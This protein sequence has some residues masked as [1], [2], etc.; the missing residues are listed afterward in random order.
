MENYKS[1]Y[2]HSSDHGD[3]DFGVVG[4]L[5]CDSHQ[6]CAE[7]GSSLA[8]DIVDSEVFARLVL[9][10][11]PGKMRSGERLDRAL[12]DC[13]EDG[14]EPEFPCLVQLKG[15]GSDS[16]IAQDRYGDQIGRVVFLRQFSEQNRERKGYNLSEE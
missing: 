8:E 12:E 13:H 7:E 5:G 11:D 16:D 1:D 6:H 14:K 9:R 4:K 2:K 10:D 15:E 3:S